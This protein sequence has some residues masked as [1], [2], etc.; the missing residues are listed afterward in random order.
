MALMQALAV[1]RTPPWPEGYES[2]NIPGAFLFYGKED[3]ASNFNVHEPFEIPMPFSLN[4]TA[5]LRAGEPIPG[6]LLLEC[7]FGEVAFQLGK[8]GAHKEREKNWADLVSIWSSSDP[9]TSKRRSGRQSGIRLPK[10]WDAW[11]RVAWML[12][13]SRCKYTI[14]R[15][16]RLLLATGERVLVENSHNADGS[17]RDVEWGGRDKQGGWTGLNLLGRVLMQ[18]RSE[19]VMAP[20][21]AM[22]G[23]EGWRDKTVVQSLL[24]GTPPQGVLITCEGTPL[25]GAVAAYGRRHNRKVIIAPSL[26]AVIAENPDIVHV[27][28]AGDGDAIPGLVAQATAHGMRALVHAGIE[29][30]AVL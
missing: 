29:I 8:V 20:R 14:P 28:R 21:I 27:W 7:T 18:V 13:I 25:A 26:Q 15:L 3:W 10:H 11:V 9:L 4:P 23:D 12:E 22:V 1:E 16:R 30:P 17:G 19:L 6:D 24:N 2:W 5:F